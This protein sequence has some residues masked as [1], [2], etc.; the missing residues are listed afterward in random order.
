[1][2]AN[3]SVSARGAITWQTP[4]EIEYDVLVDSLSRLG[5]S[6]CKPVLRSITSALTL[7][8]KEVSTAKDK[9]VIPRKKPK[10]N[11]IEIH[12]VTKHETN[13][14]VILDFGVR[15]DEEAGV[16]KADGGY[17]DE[18]KLQEE[19]IKARTRI[20]TGSVSEC[21]GKILGKLQGSRALKPSGG[22]YWLPPDSI[23]AWREVRDEMARIGASDVVFVTHDVD[24]ALAQ[25]VIKAFSTEV[26]QECLDIMERAGRGTLNKEQA[27][28]LAASADQ[29]IS[30]LTTYS[31][32]LDDPL[33]SLRSTIKLAKNAAVRAAF[34]AMGAS[35]P[36]KSAVL[37]W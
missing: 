11:G 2:T 6:D 16:V 25:E 20:P 34:K 36:A 33:Q 19:F 31:Q 23:P 35:Q 5:H 10:K 29:L 37:A 9:A 13:N 32:A 24:P 15:F 18:A 7:A 28:A 3:L 22:I 14:D 27:E 4:H 26:E 21:L 8:G 12:A 1:M 30:K 17:A